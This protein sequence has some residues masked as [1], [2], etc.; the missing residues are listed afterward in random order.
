MLLNYGRG[1]A[2]Q[3]RLHPTLGSAPNFVPPL[4]CFFLAA[5]LF[6]PPLVRWA[7]AVYGAAVLLQALAIVPLKKWHWLPG[8]GGLIATSHILYGLGF[9][10]GCLTR[11]RPPLAAVVAEVKIERL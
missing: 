7:L 3:F 9:W 8:I 5:W 4:F 11:P 6:L 2:E 10:R 1:R